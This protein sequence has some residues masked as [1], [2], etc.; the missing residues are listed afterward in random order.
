[1]PL[2]PA[3]PAPS[4]SPIAL[5]LKAKVLLLVIVPLLLFAAVVAVLG[6]QMQRELSRDQQAFLE[7]AVFD[8]QGQELE[9]LLSLAF[10]MF[11]QVMERPDLT[12]V[13]KQMRVLGMIQD[14]LTFGKDGYFFVYTADGVNLANPLDRGLVGQSLWDHQDDRGTYAIREL[15]AQARLGD[16]GAPVHYRWQRPSTKRIENKI[17]YARLLA[18]GD[19]DWLVGTGLYDVRGGLEQRMADGNA[20]IQRT[21][22]HIQWLFAGVILLMIVLVWLTNLREARLADQRLRALI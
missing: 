2:S 5:S 20:R 18:P 9:L 15:M 7:S 11:E 3:D 21:F 19:W 12:K 17:G 6:Q 8:A 14:E 10:S 16:A 4:P 13:E 1:M 22:R